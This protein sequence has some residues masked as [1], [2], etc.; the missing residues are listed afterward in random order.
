MEDKLLRK[1]E[2]GKWEGK[3]KK[4]KKEGKEK[5]TRER[6]KGGESDERKGERERE[7]RWNSGC[8][9]PRFVWSQLAL[10]ITPSF[11]LTTP[12]LP[13]FACLSVYQPMC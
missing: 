11:E 9:P 2:R 5:Y 10:S 1:R 13:H 6:G 8:P 12:T 4:K 3:R 7:K